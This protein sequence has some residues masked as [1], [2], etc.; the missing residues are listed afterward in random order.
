MFGRFRVQRLLPL[1]L[2]VLAACA[3][4]PQ[5]PGDAVIPEGAWIT[6]RA[7]FIGTNSHDTVGTISLYQSREYPV[8]VFEP[9]FSVTDA[10]GAVVAL[11]TDGYRAE[12]VLGALLRPAG[13]QAYA[14]PP[15]LDIRRFNE[16]WLWSP[17][18]DKSVGLARLTPI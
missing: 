9:N 5:R 2:L 13:R 12:T 6:H 4:P 7:V 18:A 3:S 17:A 14:L 15:E 8:L 11:G 10:A 1:L 16:V